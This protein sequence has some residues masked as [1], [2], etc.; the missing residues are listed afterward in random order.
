MVICATAKNPR[1]IEIAYILFFLLLQ[2]DEK[3][4]ADL[5]EEL[6]CL[7]K[8]LQKL[9][10]QRD[11]LSFESISVAGEISR[12]DRMAQTEQDELGKYNIL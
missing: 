6:D 2:D 11:Q 3:H 4:Q 8:S 5:A 7:E 1:A 9:N 12:L 10:R